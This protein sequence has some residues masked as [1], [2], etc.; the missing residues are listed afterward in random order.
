MNRQQELKRAAS[1][2]SRSRAKA[3]LCEA[4]RDDLIR[5]SH[6]S[7]DLGTREI[8]EL[9]ELSFQR[10]AAVVAGDPARPTRPT[11]HGAMQQVLA[12]SGG[13][14][15][16]AHELARAVFER[17]LYRRRDRGVILAGQVRARAAKYPDLFE[18]TLD[19]TNRIRL[20]GEC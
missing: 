1:A 2:V 10:V 18:A 19:G 20:R 7:G 4:R 11:L 12:D 14:W 16:A 6:R 15:V 5:A 13:G 17:G 8:A 3:A 9:V